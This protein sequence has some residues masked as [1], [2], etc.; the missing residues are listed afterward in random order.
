MSI[1]TTHTKKVTYKGEEYVV[2]VW[3]KWMAT[4]DNLCVTAFECKPKYSQADGEWMNGIAKGRWQVVKN[5]SYH[6][7]AYGSLMP[8]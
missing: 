8:V 2:P 4:D 7:P 1:R 5:P 6:N 3:T